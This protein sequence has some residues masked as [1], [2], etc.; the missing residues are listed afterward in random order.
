LNPQRPKNGPASGTLRPIYHP[1]GDEGEM[2]VYAGDLQVRANGEERTLTGQVELRLFPESDVRVRLTG[3]NDQLLPVASIFNEE[4]IVSVPDGASLATP[5]GPVLP[6]G[7]AEKPWSE[8][9]INPGR[10]EAGDLAS[11]ERLVVHVTRALEPHLRA[12]PDGSEAH[13]R[14]ELPG[15]SLVLAPV[16][17]PT[18]DDR[19]F[20]GVI[21][22]EPTGGTIGAPDVERLTYRLFILLSL[23]ASHEVGV[24][25]VCGLDARGE[26]IWAQWGAPRM[27]PGRSGAGWCPRPHIAA[28]LPALSEGYTELAADPAMEQVFERGV[29]TLVFADSKEV[30]DVRI[31][32]A[33]S[34]LELLSWAI[35]RRREWID[36]NTF[37]QMDAGSVVRLLLRWAGVPPEI[38]ARFTELEKRKRAFGMPHWGGPEVLFYVRNRLIHPPKKLDDPE[39]PDTDEMVECWQLAT[40]YLQLVI[41]RLLGYDGPYRSRLRL[42]GSEL[43]VE[44]VRGQRTLQ[45]DGLDRAAK[46]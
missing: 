11:A 38:P 46:R 39:W 3:P 23:I 44:P 13:V 43:T 40:W 32:I 36:Q 10:L 8:E 27:R 30:L 16:K 22:A 19:D 28:A 9:Q 37:T 15:W 14:F 33:C 45:R 41:L 31:P 21:E 20:G 4:Q 26:I 6:A 12:P 25:P 5:A 24:G 2:I 18:P 42:G 17:K 35:L 1:S 29:N 34:G 7:P